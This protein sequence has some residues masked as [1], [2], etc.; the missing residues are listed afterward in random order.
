MTMMEWDERLSVGV[1]SIDEQHKHLLDMINYLYDALQDGHGQEAM[2]KTFNELV[3]YTVTHFKHEEELMAASDFP[4]TAVHHDEHEYLSRCTLALQ[5]RA[6][7]GG[8]AI[9]VEAMQFLR[10]WL[11]HHISGTDKAFGQYLQSRNMH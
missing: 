6:Q 1:A 7:A 8:I 9:T 3:D 11:I 2:V 5:E 4:G 10:N